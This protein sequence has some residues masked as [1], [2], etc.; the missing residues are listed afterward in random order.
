MGLAHR[1]IKNRKIPLVIRK[2]KRKRVKIIEEGRNRETVG[3]VGSARK[4]NP[5][6]I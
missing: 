6:P 2:R 5:K 4:N 1:S 3:M